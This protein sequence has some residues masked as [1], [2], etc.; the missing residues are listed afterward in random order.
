MHL[1]KYL[2]QRN[3]PKNSK[4]E[5]ENEAKQ[6]KISE[7]EPK[8]NEVENANKLKAHQEASLMEEVE[9]L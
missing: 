3:L 9:N 7:L 6:K 8:L 4:L 5:Q 2:S 1:L